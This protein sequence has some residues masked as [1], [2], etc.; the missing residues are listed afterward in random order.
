MAA[1]C[2]VLLALVLTLLLLVAWKRWRWGRAARH[3]IVV[4]LGDVGRSPRMQYHALSLAKCGFSVTF[5]GFCSE[6]LGGLGG[7]LLSQPLTLGFDRPTGAEAG[8][9]LYPLLRRAAL[10][11]WTSRVVA[12]T[13]VARFLPSLCWV[14]PWE[15][16]ALIERLPYARTVLS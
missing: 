11:G 12:W 3:V 14:G 9:P 8:T 4:V 15:Q 6:C 7:R 2:V 13:A 1:S 10:R 5:L 16:S